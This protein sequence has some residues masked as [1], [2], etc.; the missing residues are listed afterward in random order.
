MGLINKNQS[1][2]SLVEVMLYISI[3]TIIMITLSYFMFTVIKTRVKSQTITEVD[4][5]GNQAIYLIA[6]KIRNS[7]SVSLPIPHQSSDSITL[8]TFEETNNPTV[9][10]LIDGKV[11]LSEGTSDPIQI[12]SN[13]VTITKLDISNIS[14]DSRIFRIDLEVTHRNPENIIEYNFT[15][16]FT[17]SAAIRYEYL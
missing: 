3:S 5:Q 2:M 13:R 4:Y 12:T 17:G 15:E 16:S 6:E 8:I 10:S 14:D 1:G 7:K 11:F 9:F